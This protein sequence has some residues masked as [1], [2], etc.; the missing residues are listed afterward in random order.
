MERRI[1]KNPPVKE[2]VCEIRFNRIEN[3][4]A[5]VPGLMY[6]RLKKEFPKKEQVKSLEAELGNS[7][8]GFQHNIKLTESLQIK[9][10]KE[11]ALVNISPHRLLISHLS[12]YTNWEHF[13]KLIDMTLNVYNEI[14]NPKDIERIGLRYINEIPFS[15]EKCELKDYFNFYP[16]LGSDL[17]QDY[18]SFISGIQISFDKRM[19]NLKLQMT[20]NGP[21]IILDLDYFVTDSKYISLDNIF[22]WLDKAHNR[23]IT[24]FEGSIN[25]NLR[26]I[27]GE[28]R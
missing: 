23:I 19:N 11:D 17:P 12:T 2:V 20:N 6:E 9:T 3:W 21:S 5:T 22:P 14:N 7:P 24:T 8:V 25:D 26:A 15:N 16:Y 13:L 1:Y 10:D 4:D 28:E 27:F 18:S